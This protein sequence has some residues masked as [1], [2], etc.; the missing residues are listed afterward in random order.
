MNGFD[1]LKEMHRRGETRYVPV[2]VLTTSSR[3]RE[4]VE[5]YCPRENGLVSKPLKFGDFLGP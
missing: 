5:S 3:D 4:I 1:D 2:V